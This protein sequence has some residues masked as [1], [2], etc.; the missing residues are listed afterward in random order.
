MHTSLEGKI[1]GYLCTSGTYVLALS[2][3]VPRPL[4]DLSRN[5]GEKSGTD[6][7]KIKSGS[8]LGMRLSTFHSNSV[9]IGL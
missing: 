3:L 6:N 9:H 5:R 1:D 4:P 7:C 8:G 2:S